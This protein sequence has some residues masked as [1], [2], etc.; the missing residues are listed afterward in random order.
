M[1][2]LLRDQMRNYDSDQSGAIRTGQLAQNVKEWNTVIQKAGRIAQS[3]AK[4]K[5]D[6]DQSM[7][8]TEI[9]ETGA[10]ELMQWNAKQIA[11]GVDPTTDAYTQKLYAERD[12]IYQPLIDKMGTQK[13]REF[14]QKQ[15]LDTGENIRQAN[16]KKIGQLRQRAQAAAAFNTASNR[17]KT[18]AQE[19]GKNGDWEG[20]QEASKPAR[21]AMIK[22]AKAQGGDSAAAA[23]ALRIDTSS[24]L[25]FLGGM[26]QEDPETVLTMLDDK[27]SL[28]KIVYDKLDEMYP[29]ATAEQK[30]KM[31]ES[32]Y[33]KS[34]QKA[35]A[36]EQLSAIMPE[37]V[38][39]AYV[40][41]YTKAKEA[42]KKDLQERL[43]SLP[44][45]SR[46]YKSVQEQIKKIDS[47]LDNPEQGALEL[48]RSELNRS[49]IRDMAR[50]QLQE[51]KLREKQQDEQNFVTTHIAA[52]SPDQMTRFEAR[53]NLALVPMAK[54]R[55]DNFW[56]SS[57]V[58]PQSFK[59]MYDDYLEE[60][61]KILENTKVT[62]EGTNALAAAVNKALQ[63]GEMP[64]VERVANMFEALTELH[65]TPGLTQGEFE[66]VENILHAGMLDSVFG[67]MSAEVL[68][69]GDR[70]F[71]DTNWVTNIFNPT[72]YSKNLQLGMMGLP[73]KETRDVD[74]DRV[75]DYLDANAIRIT[76]TAVAMLGEA[77]KAPTTELRQAGVQEVANY[78]ASEKQKVYDSAMKNF[79]IDLARLR[80]EK[81][82]KG[83]AFTQ[84]GWRWKEYLGD[85]PDGKPLFENAQSNEVM[86][87]VR[88][89]IIE[90]LEASA[91]KGE[92]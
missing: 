21:D 56:N 3:Y 89:R 31:F 42:E 75:Q 80:D 6:A 38:K 29:N 64:D 16:I 71:A 33:G 54:K 60:D 53:S 66:H 26:A 88:K 91:K 59:Q 13:G 81:Q 83:R 50:K 65:K 25:N 7:I 14:L 52:I 5:V 19:F 39:T 55:M 47:D 27:D 68:Q 48:L 11:A 20:Y 63:P 86:N 35:S 24:M 79:G 73:S 1:V 12:R 76:D 45:D 49:P 58:T 17:L 46:A 23:E 72:A 8:N 43:K 4:D 40:A 32:A 84:I 15:A 90:G 28:R 87:A 18:D 22:Y 10:T 2:Q 78:I 34:G 82:K 30:E 69:S 61:K 37:S 77:S 85:D 51:N 57:K 41:H 44:K 36:D 92:E 9:G 67:K 62:F 74:I 70:Y